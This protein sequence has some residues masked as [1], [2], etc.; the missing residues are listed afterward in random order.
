MNGVLLF[1]SDLSPLSDERRS[2]QGR[3]WGGSS[4]R[5]RKRQGHPGGGDGRGLWGL[6]EPLP[7]PVHVRDGLE[8]PKQPE[9]QHFWG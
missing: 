4:Q 5:D 1:P 6:S 2:W 8:M 9:E 7:H 3:G